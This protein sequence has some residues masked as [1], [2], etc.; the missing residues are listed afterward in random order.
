MREIGEGSSGY[1][2]DQAET[3]AE[4]ALDGLH[5]TRS[6]VAAQT[7]E[8][9][10]PGPQPQ[11]ALQGGAS[12]AT[13]KSVDLQVRPVHHR[14]ADRGRAHIFIRMRAYRVRWHLERKWA[15]P[16]DRGEQPRPVEDQVAPAER[17]A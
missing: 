4:A 6:N 9:R 5:A 2:R 14:L 11:A 16:L 1:R 17:S 10:G 3:A 15:S 7:L 12:L 13:M 8:R